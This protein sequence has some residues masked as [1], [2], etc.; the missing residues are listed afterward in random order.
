MLRAIDIFNFKLFLQI[1]FY[2]E[3]SQFL[4]SGDEKDPLGVNIHV[5][6]V[7]N[8]FMPFVCQKVIIVLNK[9]YMD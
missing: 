9:W 8:I 2:N 1:V 6:I 5:F 7:D 3:S 4:K